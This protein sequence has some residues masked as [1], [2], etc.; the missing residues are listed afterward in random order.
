MTLDK[1]REEKIQVERNSEQDSLLSASKPLHE[2]QSSSKT[3]LIGNQFKGFLKKRLL[4]IRRDKKI[5]VCEFLVPIVMVL[6]GVLFTNLTFIKNEPM[7]MME[8]QL[9]PKKLLINNRPE[10]ER[11]VENLPPGF[12]VTR[13]DA[14][15]HEKFS[16][17]LFQRSSDDNNYGFLMKEDDNSYAVDVYFNTTAPFGPFV[18]INLFN[19]NLLKRLSNNPDSYIKMGLHPLIQTAKIQIYEKAVGGLLLVLFLSLGYAFIPASL[20]TS[21]VKERQNDSKHQ[22]IVSGGSIWLYWLVNFTIDFLKYL[23]IMAFTLVTIKLANIE[24]FLEEDHYQMFFLLLLSNGVTMLW[25]TYLLSLFFTT[26]FNAQIFVFILNY[27]FSVV[28]VVMSLA[29]KFLEVTR[30]IWN[31]Y[32]KVFMFFPPYSFSMGTLNFTM[33][34]A[35]EQYKIVPNGKAF[36][37]EIS[38]KYLVYLSSLSV[39]YFLILFVLE[40]KSYSNLKYKKKANKNH[41][42]FLQGS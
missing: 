35:Y 10:T 9:Y 41:I 7:L 13:I 2:L 21:L 28:F 5:M 4:E 23:V 11:F 15:D 38:L 30:E 31:S 25:T 37:W 24:L 19:N 26:P 3:S 27:L 22:Q 20:I 42:K 14:D 32:E 39:F 18:G 40:L 8:P 12:E 17:E 34:F 33:V 16:D 36:N 29:F 6:L 1:D